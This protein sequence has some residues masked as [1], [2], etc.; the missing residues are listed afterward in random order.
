MLEELVGPAP[1]RTRV[2]VTHDPAHVLAQADLALGL[3]RGRATFLGLLA[4]GARRPLRVTRAAPAIL[5]KD[6]L[7]EL[8][9]RESV[10][11]MAPSRSPPSCSST[12]ASTARRSTALAAGV[13]WVT[14]LLASVLGVGRLW[15]SERDGGTLDGL[16]LAPVDCTA[17]WAAKA[18]ALLL[19]L[20]LLE[21]VAVPAFAVLLLGPELGPVLL[22]LAALLALADLAVAAVGTLVGALAA[23]SRAREL[24]TPL[25]LPCSCPWPSP[26]SATAPLLERAPELEGLG[27][28]A[29]VLG[30]YGMVFVLLSVA[31][32]DFLMED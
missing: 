2:L 32:F 14:L 26:G 17:L 28:W 7:L 12:S 11:A 13:L 25:L 10:P 31:V 1:G 8:R 18:L 30:L 9:T 15:A 4:R 19:Y 22:P 23:E 16:L 24:I 27:R 5:R 20:A 6:L 29:G 3:R 21:L